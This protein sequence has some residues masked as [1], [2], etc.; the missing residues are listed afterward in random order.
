[1]DYVFNDFAIELPC[2]RRDAYP[3]SILRVNLPAILL[4]MSCDTVANSKVQDPCLFLVAMHVYF[5]WW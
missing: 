3:M 2:G 4:E 1:M 5:D